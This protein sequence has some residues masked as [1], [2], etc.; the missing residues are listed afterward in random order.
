MSDNS[1]YTPIGDWVDWMGGLCPIKGDILIEIKLR[2]TTTAVGKAGIWWWGVEGGIGDI[3]AF[4]L[5]EEAKPIEIGKVIA[6]DSLSWPRIEFF[7]SAK[8]LKEG[9]LLY[10]EGG[11]TQPDYKAQL[12]AERWRYARRYLSIED[13][14]LWQT[15]MEGHQPS[16]EESVKADSTIDAAIASV[17]GGTS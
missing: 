7:A 9:T 16:E 10:V 13:I 8:Q 4:R 3:T 5:V 6:S 15:E 2:G 14:E 12:D 17:K 1:K 11:A